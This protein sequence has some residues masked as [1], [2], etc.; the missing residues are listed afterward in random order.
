DSAVLPKFGWQDLDR[1]S[2]ARYRQLFRVTSPTHPANAYDDQR[3][4]EAIGGTRRDRDAGVEGLTVAGLLMFGTPE[5]IRE[6]RTRHLIDYRLLP[7]DTGLETR[8]EDR[9]TWEGNLLDA[10]E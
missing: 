6:W 5:A 1:E 2:L 4:L 9:V 10:F 7:G 3:F 8:W